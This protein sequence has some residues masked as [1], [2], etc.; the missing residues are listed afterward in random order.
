MPIGVT[1][2]VLSTLTGGLLGAALGQKIPE[3]IKNGLRTGFPFC[4]F[5]I[6]ITLI[7]RV[8]HLPA[9]AISILLGIILGEALNINDRIIKAS[10]SINSRLTK[11][12]KREEDNSIKEIVSLM[13]LVCLSGTGIFGALNEAI[14]GEHS[15]LFAKAALDLFSTAIFASTMG[16]FVALLF[17]PQAAVYTFLIL[18]APLLYPVLSGPAYGDFSAT[19]GI[20][21]LVAGFNLLRLKEIKVMNFLPA[22]ILII[23][24]SSLWS[25]IFP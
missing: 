16:Y 9:V 6:G 13:F 12:M 1:V 22:M 5:A 7:I 20:I 3:K 4:S 21:S 19:T 10:E 18:L 25:N 8:S 14:R 11:I 2:S 15:F 23:P 17:L 24:I